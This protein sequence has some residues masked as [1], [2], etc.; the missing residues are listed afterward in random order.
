MIFQGS[1]NG[2]HFVGD[3]TRLKC[4]V[5]SRDVPFTSALLAQNVDV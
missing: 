5:I 3:Q 4:M 1:L 2:T